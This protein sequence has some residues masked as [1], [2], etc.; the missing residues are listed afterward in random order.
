M[1][2]C[3]LATQTELISLCSHSPVCPAPLPPAD[4]ANP[5]SFLGM[6]FSVTSSTEPS[7]TPPLLLSCTCLVPQSSVCFP[8][9]STCHTSFFNFFIFPDYITENSNFT[10]ICNVESESLLKSHPTDR[11]SFKS[12]LYTSSYFSM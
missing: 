8:N 4:V 2:E 10:E 6:R 12:W 11:T 9:R 7:V 3:T 1:I 5:W